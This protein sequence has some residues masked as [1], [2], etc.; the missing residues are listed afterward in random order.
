M[1]LASVAA[2]VLALAILVLAKPVKKRIFPNRKARFVTLVIDQNASL[3][4]LRSEVDA[5]NLILDRIVVRPGPSH[6]RDS[7]ELVLGKGSDEED[8]LSLTDKLRRI[9]GVHEVD[10]VLDGPAHSRN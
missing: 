9:S 2:T 8:L 5:S 3:A 6:D 1:F 10:S 4:G 7:A